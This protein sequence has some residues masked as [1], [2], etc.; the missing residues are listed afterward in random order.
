MATTTT[1]TMGD[2]IEETLDLLH[3]ATERPRRAVVGSTALSSTSDTSLTLSDG[4]DSVNVT[5]LLEF[6]QELLLV[7]A[8]SDAATP[9]LTVQRGYLGTTATAHATGDVGRINP[10]FPRY[11][12]QRAIEQAIRSIEV[13][14]PC[15]STEVYN[16]V[17]S[18]Q[19][20]SLPS[21]TIEVLQVRLLNEETFKFTDLAGWEFLEDLPTDLVASTKAVKVPR[22]VE[23]DTDLY[24][25]RQIPFAWSDTTP[26]EESTI[27]LPLGAGDLP[28]LYAT[29]RLSTGREVS[30][31]EVDNVTEWNKEAAIRGGVN[32]RAIRDLWAD[33]Y[34][35]L[36]EVRRLQNVPRRRVFRK[37]PRL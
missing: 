35:R 33:Y 30:R 18:R 15:L 16:R 8:K 36:D 14:M 17:E 4:I 21:N 24:V 22:A 25:T 29:A 13:W 20:A 3:R 32:L 19:Y 6:G 7:T 10:P 12:V 26:D 23:D 37:V 27:A 9:V 11:Q 1:L 2:L 34:R 31:L 5:D 28:V